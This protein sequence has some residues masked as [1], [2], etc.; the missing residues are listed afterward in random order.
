MVLN[1]AGRVLQEPE[2]FRKPDQPVE[3]HSSRD[4]ARK[5]GRLVLAEIDPRRIAQQVEDLVQV[6]LSQGLDRKLIRMLF[7]TGH[8]RM[9]PAIRLVPA[10]I[11]SAEGT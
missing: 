6:A 10:A 11:A 3:Q 9:T 1:F 5:S 4:A 2:V 8:I 7:G